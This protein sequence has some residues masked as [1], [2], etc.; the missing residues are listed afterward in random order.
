MS[1]RK[2]VDGAMKYG[3]KVPEKTK[4]ALNW[5]KIN[6]AVNLPKPETIQQKYQ[7]ILDDLKNSKRKAIA[8]GGGIGAGALGVAALS[9]DKEEQSPDMEQLIEQLR[10]QGLSDEE[11]AV[12]LDNMMQAQ[13]E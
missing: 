13:G 2:I 5:E 12:Y 6:H 11:I 3:K 10:Q 1:W 4:E 9:D 7:N 8:L